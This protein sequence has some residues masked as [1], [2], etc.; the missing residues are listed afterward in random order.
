M[1]KRIVIHN[2]SIHYFRV[3]LSETIGTGAAAV[4]LEGWIRHVWAKD[5]Q[6][7]AMK[8]LMFHMRKNPGTEPRLV[9]V[10]REDYD[11]PLEI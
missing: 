11:R 5:K 2:T 4:N 9:A 10:E 1:A 3:K 8:A 7:A 6:E